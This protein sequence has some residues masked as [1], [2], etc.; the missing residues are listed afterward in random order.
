MIRR[1]P[2]GSAV[3]AA[4]LLAAACATA[5]PRP[6]TLAAT[7]WV[8]SAAEYEAAAEQIYRAATAALD[9]AAADSTWT[10]ALEQSGD[11]VALPPAVIVDVDETVLDN[12]PYEAWTI[13][14]G[15][16]FEPETWG[17][18]VR[19][20]EAEPVPGALGFLREAVRRGIT[21]FYVTNRDH[22]L[23]EATRRNL[24][25]HGFPLEEGRDVLLTRGERQGWTG[26][27]TSR[28]AAV[29]DSFRVL[30]LVGDNLGDFVSADLPAAER[31]ALVRRHRDRWGEKWFLLPNPIYGSWEEAAELE[32]WSGPR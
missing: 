21:V 26:D 1:A 5:P 18:W 12:T 20:A 17:A 6:E 11:R 27:K 3:L 2:G 29:A 22:A 23:E 28:R 19:A 9:R 14:E 4:A 16:E 13:A 24:A 8:Q 32:A 31:D 10:A 25:L 15:E 30:L 7:L